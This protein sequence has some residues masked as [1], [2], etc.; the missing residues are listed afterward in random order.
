M[1][2]KCLQGRNKGSDA[3]H[4][5]ILSKLFDFLEKAQLNVAVIL[6]MLCDFGYVEF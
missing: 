5:A 1:T 4:A 3:N 6:A 2:T